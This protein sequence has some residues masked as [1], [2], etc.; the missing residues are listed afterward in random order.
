[1]SNMKKYLVTAV[2]LGVIAMASGLLIGLTNMVTRDQIVQNEINNINKGIGEIFGKEA[3]I[4]EQ[5]AVKDYQYVSERYVVEENNAVSGYAFK[6]VG[7]NSYGKVSVIIGFASNDYAFKGLYIITNEQTYASTLVENYIDPLNE[8]NREVAD[9]SC[10]ATYG[11]KLV[12]DMINEAKQAA[13][14]YK[15]A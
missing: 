5:E 13:E 11:A 2:T 3:S 6:T 1:M 15:G 4:K 8:G 9:V 7:S 12:R 14:N 10:G